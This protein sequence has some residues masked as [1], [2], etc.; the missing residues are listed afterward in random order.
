MTDSSGVAGGS[1]F[2][3]PS[4]SPVLAA[5]EASSDRLVTVPAAP[6]HDV[7]L[8]APAAR[9]FLAMQAAARDDD[10][11]LVAVSG[12]R[13][14]AR[15]TRIWNRKIETSLT[16]GLETTD[17]VTQALRY[18]A[19]PGWSRHHAGTDLDLVDAALGFDPRLEP[20]DWD[21]DGPCSPSNL[22]LA[23]HAADFGFARPYDVD[24]GGFK[25]EPWHWS[26]VPS[27]VPWLRRVRRL[28][29]S[30]WFAA[31]PY[32]GSDV[33]RTRGRELFETFV[34]RLGAPFAT[35]E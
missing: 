4:L 20:E 3:S 17:A 13:S 16:A 2:T 5:V 35:G 19:P 28:D 14:V 10:V 32:F 34:V 1:D 11:G 21:D 24:R 26:F 6:D 25:P 27:A 15:Q 18:S 29:W 8:L 30:D 22:W 33:I 7:A 12:F 23:A 31:T 9:A